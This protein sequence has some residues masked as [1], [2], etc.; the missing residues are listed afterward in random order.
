MK[1]LFI[2]ARCIEGKKTGVGRVLYD[3]L[4]R[5]NIDGIKMILVFDKN[6]DIDEVNKWKSKGFSV[7]ILGSS[8]FIV[9][10]QLLFKRLVKNDDYV[11]F[12]SNTGCIF[13][14]NIIVTIHDTI[15][16][17]SFKKIKLSGSMYKDLGR[18]YRKAIV[19]IVAR[20]SKLILT[21]SENSKKDIM[22]RYNINENKVKVNYNGLSNQFYNEQLLNK[23]RNEK[24][25]YILSF[26]SN[27][28]RKNT[29]KTLMIFKRMIDEK[30]ISDDYKL[31]LFG[32]RG[33]S[34]SK[35]NQFILENG[36]QDRVEIHEYIDDKKL[37]ELYQNAR[38]FLFLSSYEGFGIPIIEA[39]SQGTPVIAA[40]NSSLTEIVGESGILVDLDND[41]EIINSIQLLIDNDE[42]FNQYI[43]KGYKNVSNYNWD[44]IVKN[45]EREI[46][47][48]LGLG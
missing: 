44:N 16:A 6:V 19:P 15:F 35:G 42:I 24:D 34:G 43:E 10:E 1:Q 33:Y 30:K 5:I 26:G 39:M 11:W 47:I 38:M 13:C 31:V 14:K 7:E 40:D 28:V 25:K 9:V 41:D 4:D 32:Y 20:R 36:L 8:N 45:I 48:V 37:I 2:D 12:P 22:N 17:E 46:S 27:E 29:I 23:C 21:V 18:I 3:I